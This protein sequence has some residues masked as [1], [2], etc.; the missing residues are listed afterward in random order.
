MEAAI[1]A[2]IA[3]TTASVADVATD[4]IPEI[5]VV[6]G[7]LVA[8]GLILRLVKRLIGRRV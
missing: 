2:A 7:A 1:T 4:N 8:F 5:M 3:S 6:F